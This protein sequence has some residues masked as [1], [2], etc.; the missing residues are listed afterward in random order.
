MS[1]TSSR[2]VRF[3][4]DIAR[5]FGK[6]KL[7]ARLGQGGMAEV[8]L[9]VAVG[10]SGFNKLLVIKRLRPELAEDPAFVSMFLDE[11]R[12]AARLNHPNVVQANEVGTI[13]GQH[14]LAM[15]YLDGQPLNRLYT[16]ARTN[17]LQPTAAYL[18][19]VSD[20][21]AGLHYAHEL[22]DYDGSPLNVVHR[23]VSPHN[24]FITY[25]GQVKLVDFGV[26]K[27]ATHAQR[28]STGVVKGK[29]S[30]MAPEQALLV[31]VDRRA[32]IFSL[33]V[34]L[35]ELI[36][37][38]RFWGD[39]SEIQILKEMTMSDVLGDRAEGIPAEL[40]RIC[41]RALAVV[42]SDRYATAAEFR[43]DLELF[44]Q[45]SADRASPTDLGRMLGGLFVDQRREL[46]SI[47]QEQLSEIAPSGPLSARSAAAAQ[48]AQPAAAPQNTWT[49]PA[50]SVSAEE[51]PHSDPPVGTLRSGFPPPAPRSEQPTAPELDAQ[52]R[53]DRSEL[54]VP[55]LSVGRS[56]EGGIPPSVSGIVTTDATIARLAPKKRG[57]L[58]PAV[59]IGA[60][61][62]LGAGLFFALR[63]GEPTPRTA[64]TAAPMQ[65]PA[66]SAERVQA[67]ALI[68][69]RIAA[70]P[71]AATIYLDDAAV[72]GNPFTAKFPSDGSGHRIRAEAPGHR[73]HSQ[74]IAFSKDI[75]LDITL[76]SA[77]VAEHPLAVDAGAPSTAPTGAPIR[78]VPG[79]TEKKV[80][81]E[82][83]PWK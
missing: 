16:V 10:P 21:L 29:L 56:P 72:S 30:Y 43:D 34:I 22:A 83:D 82:R 67:P 66:P 35:W 32:D 26:A 25:D 58:V 41:R 27:A 68:E 2:A 28:T 81:D 3:A 11:A 78:F 15:E 64:G 19:L 8:F 33:G 31:T 73:P 60:S 69:I 18:R 23:D 54:A 52:S 36:T 48:S 1:V 62:L 24:V 42:P 74:M 46:R 39:R 12:L 9:A 59:L 65:P 40:N 80:V 20:A 63:L 79:R 5:S 38:Q 37:A 75:T 45:Q 61:L 53:P 76:E 47:I 49:T 57:A 6:Y 4:L 51:A 71:A 17:S 7:L 50:Q 44:I 77:P 14:Y 70:K 55:A 13:D